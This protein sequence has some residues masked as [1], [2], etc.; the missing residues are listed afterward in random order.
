VAEAGGHEKGKET[1]R[2]N[3]WVWCGQAGACG[4]QYQECWLKHASKP[5]APT[6]LPLGGSSSRADV[7]WTSGVVYPDP[8]AYLEAVKGKTKLLM[9]TPLG[10]IPIQLLPDLAPRSVAEL[11]RGAA[12]LLPRQ[13]YCSGCNIYRNEAKFLLQGVI[14]APGVYVA[15]PRHPNP[16][17]RKV[18]QRGLICWAGGAGGPDWFINLIDQSGFGDDHLCWGLVDQGEGMA[19]VDRIVGQP[20]APKKNPSDMTY[21][22]TRLYFNLTLE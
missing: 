17:Q 9:H 13:G 21:L 7:P 2:C 10:V 19:L 3:V 22:A 6:E 11:Q 16:P 20:L 12:F 14:S 15:G 1:M 8:D 18:M 5:P 4:Q